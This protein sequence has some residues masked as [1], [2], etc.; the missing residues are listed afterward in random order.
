MI[1]YGD[2]LPESISNRERS[3]R[4]F[5]LCG[6]LPCAEL[7][8]RV[9]DDHERRQQ[10]DEPERKVEA[11]CHAGQPGDDHECEDAVQDRMSAEGAHHAAAALGLATRPGARG[12][13]TCVG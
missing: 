11:G 12:A 4:A 6:D 13:H 2:G 7:G 10:I 5:D 3:E 1:P 9:G 8:E